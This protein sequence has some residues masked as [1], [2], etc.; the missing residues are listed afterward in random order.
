MEIHPVDLA[1]ESTHCVVRGDRNYALPEIRAIDQQR[2]TA[3]AR[4]QIE[5][6]RHLRLLAPKFLCRLNAFPISRTLSGGQGT[7][8]LAGQG[9]PATRAAWAAVSDNFTK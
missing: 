9:A 3:E 4:R 8:T 7:T 1:Y 5:N 6:Y 2:Q